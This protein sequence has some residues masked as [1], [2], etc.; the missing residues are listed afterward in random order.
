QL[1]GSRIKEVE[2]QWVMVIAPAE[3][4]GSLK[5]EGSERT[6]PLHPA[7]VEAGFLDF[8]RERGQ[9]PLFYRRSSGKASKR[10]ASKGVSNRLSAWIRAAGFTDPRKAPAHA[11]RHWF[12]SA[13][14]RRGVA[15]S[16]ADAIQG[17]ATASVASRYRHF[18][19]KDMAKALAAIPLPPPTV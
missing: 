13:A 16:L 19:M 15:D 5:N 4:G 14:S 2:G 3:D 18:D 11:F 9:G 17:H 12:K 7:L 10:H 1:W 6:V 8:V